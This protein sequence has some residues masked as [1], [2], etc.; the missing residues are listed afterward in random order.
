MDVPNE[1]KDETMTVFVDAI[2]LSEISLRLVWGAENEDF[3]V[4]VRCMNDAFAVIERYEGREVGEVSD[5]AYQVACVLHRHSSDY[6]DKGRPI[7]VASLRL[8]IGAAWI[9]VVDLMSEAPTHPS[10]LAKHLLDVVCSPNVSALMLREITETTTA[11]QYHLSHQPGRADL[12]V[13][14]RLWSVVLFAADHRLDVEDDVLTRWSI[15][16]QLLFRHIEAE[17]L[18]RV[19]K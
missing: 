13:V 2:Y 16:Q 6:V 11:V 14:L 5:Q 4:V 9:D 15:E 17:E 3:G 7:D 19:S 12:D 18:G 8:E 1:G 10:L